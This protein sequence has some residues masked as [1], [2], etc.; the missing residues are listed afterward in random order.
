MYTVRHHTFRIIRNSKT[1]KKKKTESK[2]LLYFHFVVVRYIIFFFFVNI[3]R[4]RIVKN[5][6]NI[7]YNA[8]DIRINIYFFVLFFTILFGSIIHRI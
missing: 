7:R 8:N 3:I 1:K 6:Q 2:L 5:K 4:R